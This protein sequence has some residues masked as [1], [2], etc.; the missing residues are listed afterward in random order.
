MLKQSYVLMAA[1]AGVLVFTGCATSAVNRERLKEEIKQEILA[2]LRGQDLPSASA[3]TTLEEER[4]RMKEEL[5]REILATIQEQQQARKR[6]T[7]NANRQTEQEIRGAVGAAEG[8]ITRDGAGLP[9]CRVKLVRVIRA[10]NMIE[11]L[12][13]LQEGAEYTTVT[14]KEGK[15]QFYNLPAGDYKVKW[16]LPR[17]KGWIRRLKDKPDVTVQEGKTSF[18]KPIETN[19]R[20]V[21][22]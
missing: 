22:S 16:Q 4:A 12:S 11:V 14:D 21:T 5:E 13:A 17:D 9:E 1:L 18:L 10:N 8:L 19:R 20:L 3:Q 15:Y 7:A 6:D 2:E